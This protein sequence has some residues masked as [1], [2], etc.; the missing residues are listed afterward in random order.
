[1][2]DISKQVRKMVRINHKPEFIFEIGERVSY[3]RGGAASGAVIEERKHVK[4]HFLSNAWSV[5]IWTCVYKTVET[6]QSP[7][8]RNAPGY[9]YVRRWEDPEILLRSFDVEVPDGAV[10]YESDEFTADWVDADGNV[11]KTVKSGQSGLAHDIV[12]T[13]LLR[14]SA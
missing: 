14:K 1:M 5:P 13:S 7:L 3:I 11:I 4:D 6:I 12:S 10:D 9:P 8:G 2:K